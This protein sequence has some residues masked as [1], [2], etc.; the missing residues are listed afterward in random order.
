MAIVIKCWVLYCYCDTLLGVVSTVM[1]F[2]IA[3]VIPCHVF[4]C[5]CNAVLG[6]S[7]PL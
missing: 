6:V 5:H 1:Q 7:L 2:Y 3:T 4:H